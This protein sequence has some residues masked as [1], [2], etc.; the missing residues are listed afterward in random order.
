M[1]EKTLLGIVMVGSEARGSIG[2]LRKRRREGSEGKEE[3]GERGG[4]GRELKEV[5]I[6][7]GKD[8]NKRE[9]SVEHTS[10]VELSLMMRRL[11]SS[12]GQDA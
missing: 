12:I 2:V 11:F 7:I 5:I 3:R 1:W 6:G 10:S 8:E 9:S 4:E